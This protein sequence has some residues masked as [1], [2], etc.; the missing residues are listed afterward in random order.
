M[1]AQVL[2]LVSVEWFVFSHLIM[3]IN[4]FVFICYRN[5][6]QSLSCLLML[7]I[8]SV[9]YINSKMYNFFS[10]LGFSFL[11]KFCHIKVTGIF[12]KFFFTIMDSDR[13]TK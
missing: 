3:N 10:F 13:K 5:F 1:P 12:S 8:V 11:I 2:C 7:I 6:F 4:L 9:R